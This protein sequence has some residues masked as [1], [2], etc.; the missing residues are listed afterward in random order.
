MLAPLRTQAGYGLR[1]LQSRNA[2]RAVA[3]RLVRGVPVTRATPSDLASVH[4]K[5]SPG[6][7]P[8]PSSANPAVTNLVAKRRG[9]VIGFV[10]LVRHPPSHAPFIGYW[11]FSLCV[12][13]LMNRGSGVG[14]ALTRA[15]L[16]LARDEG[17]GEV[18]LVVGGANRPAVSLY[19]KMGFEVI[20]LPGLE[21]QMEEEAERFGA[22]RVAMVK[23]FYE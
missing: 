16:E 22:R 8:P 1:F 18:F 13:D 7:S 12:F 23:R 17:S 9:R 3:R 11:L 14:E 20:S 15:V 21:D 2:Y 6:N 4:Y 5:L 19:Q 10:Q